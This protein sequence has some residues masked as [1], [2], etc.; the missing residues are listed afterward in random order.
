MCL[1]VKQ[2]LCV[3][4]DDAAGPAGGRQRG[5]RWA[6][7]SPQ[8]ALRAFAGGPQ[9]DRGPRNTRP[10]CTPIA[11]QQPGRQ[12]PRCRWAIWARRWGLLA[13]LRP[14]ASEHQL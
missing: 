14:Q 9:R 1:T 2:T 4:R 11:G 6:C 10:G 13:A 5:S 8:T 12:G 3:A 7:R